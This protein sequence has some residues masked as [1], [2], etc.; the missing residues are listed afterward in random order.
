MASSVPGEASTL[1]EVG[2]VPQDTT[3]LRRL[4]LLPV[5][6]DTTA[7]ELET[8]SRLSVTQVLTTLLWDRATA[9]YAPPETY[10][11]GGAEL[12]QRVA[13]RVSFVLVWD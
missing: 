3:A 10:A 7:L 9:P 12:I 1:K 4:R 8:S 11:P 2:L 6:R 5:L 13:R